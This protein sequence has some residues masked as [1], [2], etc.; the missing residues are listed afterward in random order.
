MKS[1]LHIRVN[2]INM[3]II[4]DPTD[5]WKSGTYVYVR[6]GMH[7]VPAIILTRDFSNSVTIIRVLHDDYKPLMAGNYEVWSVNTDAL[8]LR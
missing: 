3:Y 6:N 4:T 7:R 5:V 8:E 1:R 2:G